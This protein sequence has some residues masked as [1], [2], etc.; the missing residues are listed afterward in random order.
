MPLYGKILFAYLVLINILSVLVT[1]SDKRRAAKHQWRIPESTLL[2]LS[3]LG[4]SLAMF[5][6]MKGIHHKTKHKKFMV[7]IPVIIFLQIVAI[8]SF[9]YWWK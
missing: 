9:F 7:G 1:V 2:L 4:G 5:L 8:T 3:A 6:T